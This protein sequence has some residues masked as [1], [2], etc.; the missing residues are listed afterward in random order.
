MADYRILRK[1]ALEFIPPM[2]L[3]EIGGIPEVSRKSSISNI[4][5]SSSRSQE[6]RASNLGMEIREG[7]LR[8]IFS[9]HDTFLRVREYRT[10]R[11]ITVHDSALDRNSEAPF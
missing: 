1:L 9:I 7:E 6:L 2:S 5:P 10:F 8:K 3:R 4:V 11:S